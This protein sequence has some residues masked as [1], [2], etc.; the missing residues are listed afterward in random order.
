M[1]DRFNSFYREHQHPFVDAMVNT[2]TESFA[3]S[4]RLPLPS[5]VYS[6]QDKFFQDNI[7]EMV[8]VSKE[9][10]DA[11]RKNP[12]DKKDLLN[13]MMKGKDP[14]TGEGL[15]DDTIIKNMITFLIAGKFGDNI[16]PMPTFGSDNI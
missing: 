8:A 2:L 6:K 11:R 14:K 16:Y 9:L 7:D 10:M 15:D 4:R 12:S 3:R 1:G 13:A 5:M